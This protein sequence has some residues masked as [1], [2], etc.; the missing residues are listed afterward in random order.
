LLA[1][2]DADSKIAL[3][4]TYGWQSLADLLEDAGYELHLAQCRDD[5]AMDHPVAI[6][7]VPFLSPPVEAIHGARRSFPTATS[8]GSSE[9]PLVS[10]LPNGAAALRKAR[11]SSPNYVARALVN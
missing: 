5:L 2:I 1:E 11:S 8:I 10:P 4:A 7:S 9:V 6:G 3:E